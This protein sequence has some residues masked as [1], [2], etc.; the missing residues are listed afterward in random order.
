MLTS[1]SECLVTAPSTMEIRLHDANLLA[2]ATPYQDI[3]VN[4]QDSWEFL[5]SI[6]E[7]LVN[8]GEFLPDQLQI[9]LELYSYDFIK[10]QYNI[11]GSIP[12]HGVIDNGKEFYLLLENNKSGD[13]FLNKLPKMEVSFTSQSAV[14]NRLNFQSDPYTQ[15]GSDLLIFNKKHIFVMELK[16]WKK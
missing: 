1:D 6:S 10:S 13:L 12:V 5:K 4:T 7:D 11:E 9:T 3:L 8:D 14:Y 2:K 15:N 16:L